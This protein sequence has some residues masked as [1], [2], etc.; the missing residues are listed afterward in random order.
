MAASLGSI[1]C[2]DRGGV[3]GA[4]HFHTLGLAS[5]TTHLAFDMSQDAARHS[6][7]EDKATARVNHLPLMVVNMVVTLSV[8]SV[9]NTHIGFC[10]DTGLHMGC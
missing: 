4:A 9:L 5:L 10:C 8:D 6:A 7:G 3:D 2:C 1:P